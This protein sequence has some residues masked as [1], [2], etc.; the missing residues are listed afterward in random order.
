M[1][2]L[3]YACL[4]IAVT[5]YLRGSI[6]PIPHRFELLARV[7][8]AVAGVGFASIGFL[9]LGNDHATVL[10]RTLLLLLASGGIVYALGLVRGRTPV[11]FA[12][13]QSGWVLVV[14][15]LAVPTT[16]TLLM[17]LACLLVLTLRSTPDPR[18]VARIS[19]PLGQ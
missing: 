17:P 16:L 12:L 18:R 9:L 4:F 19:P 11:G 8:G 1:V 10:G 14:A 6:E 3:A 2:I 7:L 13:R 5:A 15:A